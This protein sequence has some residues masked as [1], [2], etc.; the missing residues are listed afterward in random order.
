M[1]R[2]KQSF[3]PLL[4][5]LTQLSQP[6]SQFEN[7][8]LENRIEQDLIGKREPFSQCQ[9]I[10]SLIDITKSTNKTIRSNV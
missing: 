8:Y 9:E 4:T 3:L 6:F 1:R 5:R 10:K 2:S 7:E